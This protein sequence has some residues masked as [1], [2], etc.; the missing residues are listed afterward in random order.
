MA[1]VIGGWWWIGWSPA[2]AP[3]CP[4]HMADLAWAPIH[5]AAALLS[6]RT[7]PS[8]A[9]SA[10]GRLEGERGVAT[11]C[12]AADSGRLPVEYLHI[13]GRRHCAPPT[14]V[15]LGR[16]RLAA[17]LLNL[18]P[19]PACSGWSTR[20]CAGRERGGGGGALHL[21]LHVGSTL[22]SFEPRG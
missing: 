1:L 14:R 3:P 10:P 2:T 18:L 8:S 22:D 6:P 12:P 15:P 19:S 13:I 4:H 20:R 17:G 9:A 16:R 11:A 21:S 7:S 5:T